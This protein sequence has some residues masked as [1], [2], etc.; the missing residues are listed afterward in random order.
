MDCTGWEVVEGPD[1]F[2][3]GRWR[4]MWRRECIV[5]PNPP[6]VQNVETICEH[7]HPVKCSHQP[8]T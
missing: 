7:E 6:E 5:P 2:P 8:P 3:P 4:R 1:P